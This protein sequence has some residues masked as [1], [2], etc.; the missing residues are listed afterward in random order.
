VTY[1]VEREGKTF[2]LKV[3]PLSKIEMEL[4]LKEKEKVLEEHKKKI[5]QETGEVIQEKQKPII[6]KEII[7]R[8]EYQKIHKIEV[9]NDPQK[10]GVKEDEAVIKVDKK[11]D[12]DKQIELQEIKKKEAQVQDQDSTEQLKNKLENEVFLNKEVENMEF[13][14]SPFIAAQMP[15][16]LIVELNEAKVLFSM[17]ELRYF[18]TIFEEQVFAGF[19][20]LLL[21]HYKNGT[22]REF[23]LQ[24][25]KKPEEEQ[26]FKNEI[27]KMNFFDKLVKIVVDLHTMNYVHTNLSPDTIYVD[28]QFEPVIGGFEF[29]H[30]SKSMSQL[31]PEFFMTQGSFEYTTSLDKLQKD[32]MKDFNQISPEKGDEIVNSKIKLKIDNSPKHEPIKS[33]SKSSEIKLEFDLKFERSLEYL[34]PELILPESNRVF[35]FDNKLDTYSLG[36]VYFFMLYGRPPFQGK[37]KQEL[38]DNLGTRFII[39]QSGTYN[40]SISIFETS[41]S[42]IPDGRTSTYYLSIQVGMELAREF[43]QQLSQSIKIS[44]DFEYTN[45]Y[46]RDFFDKYSEMIFVLIMAFVIIPLTVFLA[47]YKFKVENQNIMN[48]END[49]ENPNQNQNQ[50]INMQQ[51]AA[52][53]QPFP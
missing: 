10:K 26:V 13:V 19:K 29:V 31:D 40:N 17:I 3:K 47:S 51:M 33:E 8:D 12:Q 43:K 14:N 16:K 48:R 44:T 25:Q 2:Q 53:N 32:Q 22:L 30:E 23:M 15:K 27:I 35:Y 24:D 28:D 1:L 18:Q 36:A 49:Q 34:A 6:E 42:L 5:E 11:L 38:I 41:L 21:E 4:Y 20:I 45:K 52:M 46:G 37:T 39:L 7:S 9:D 50:G